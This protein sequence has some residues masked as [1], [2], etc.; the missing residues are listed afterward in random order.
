MKVMKMLMKQAKV[1]KSR[2]HGRRICGRKLNNGGMSLVEV[3]VA[4]TIFAVVTV[5]VLHALTTSAFYNQKARK[6]QNVTALA[7]S[8]MENFKGYSLDSLEN[9]VFTGVAGARMLGLD[10]ENDSD[11]SYTYADPSKKDS[12]I[13]FQ[14]QNVKSEKAKYNIE[15]QAEPS[16]KEEIFEIDNVSTDRD[17]IFEFETSYDHNTYDRVKSN[18]LSKAAA[19]DSMILGDNK[20]DENGD[21][22]TVASLDKDKLKIQKRE[23]LYKIVQ[24][25]EDYVVK[26]SGAYIYQMQKHKCY[27]QYTSPPT[28]PPTGEPPTDEGEGEIPTEETSGP[29]D[30]EWVEA[31]EDQWFQSYVHYMDLMD[32]SGAHDGYDNVGDIGM[33]NIPIYDSS[34]DARDDE[35]IDGMTEKEIYRDKNLKRVLIYFYPG[36]KGSDG[37]DGNYR[38]VIKIDNRTSQQFDCYLIKQRTPDLTETK[39]TLNEQAYKPVVECKGT[40]VRLFHN[41]DENLGRST[42]TASSDIKTAE[43]ESV[44]NYTAADEF[45]KKKVMTYKLTLVVKDSSNNVLA[46]LK[47]T[48]YEKYRE[49]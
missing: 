49:Y 23:F 20:R 39:L 2:R 37:Y 32:P 7:E 22:Y 17:A 42:G 47:G 43:F 36:Y 29:A 5:P 1:R 27:E 4:M 48:M 19:I 15:I 38:D 35:I 8:V 45:K 46:E 25:G 9:E 10:I 21:L 16:V 14:I 31:D 12:A 26:V 11:I 3:I 24:E 41:L 33:H 44:A 6:R 13:T 40:K 30:G 34:H 28:P 18:F